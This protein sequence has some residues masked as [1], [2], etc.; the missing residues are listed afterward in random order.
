MSTQLEFSVESIDGSR[1]GKLS[2]P[3]QKVAD[4][5]N[6]LV[7]PKQGAQIVS[8]RQDEDYLTLYFQG[9]EGLYAYL[10]GRFNCRIGFIHPENIF[11][12]QG[13]K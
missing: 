11:I 3:T 6:F 5:I 4:W 2:V 10:D 13:L 1:L 9:D 12:G 7:S 8:A